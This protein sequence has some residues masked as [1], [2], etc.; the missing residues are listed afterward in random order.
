MPI[1][2]HK[3]R[4]TALRFRNIHHGNKIPISTIILSN[5][6]I[7]FDIYSQFE[8]LIANCIIASQMNPFYYAIEHGW[9][10]NRNTTVSFMWIIIYN[11]N[12]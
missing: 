3:S 4:F 5:Q 7:H 10:H 9:Y 12:N 1:V 2:K 11:L 8:F 6:M